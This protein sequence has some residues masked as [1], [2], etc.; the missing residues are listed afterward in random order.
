MSGVWLLWLVLRYCSTV[1]ELSQKV[2]VGMRA[3]W[4]NIKPERD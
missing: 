4:Y 1:M 2:F 3:V